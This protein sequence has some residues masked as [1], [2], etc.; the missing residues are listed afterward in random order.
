MHCTYSKW[1]YAKVNSTILIT[2]QDTH[3]RRH[4]GAITKKVGNPGLIP[5]IKYRQVKQIRVRI[6]ELNHDTSSL[7]AILSA[8]QLWQ[9]KSE[10]FANNKFS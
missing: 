2:L 3:P 8:M 5:N 10:S 7:N 6:L 9:S 1:L 4:G